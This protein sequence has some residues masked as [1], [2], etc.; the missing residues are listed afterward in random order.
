[1]AW[2]L[3]V[4]AVGSRVDPGLVGSVALSSCAHQSLDGEEEEEIWGVG[5]GEEERCG[6]SGSRAPVCTGEEFR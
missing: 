6:L 2:F 3:P 4:Q 1:M 5:A